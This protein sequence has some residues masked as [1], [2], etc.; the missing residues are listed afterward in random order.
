MGSRINFAWPYVT[1]LMLHYDFPIQ[2]EFAFEIGNM[3]IF[4][5]PLRAGEKIN[6]HL[7]N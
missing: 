5:Q 3:G 7:K 4:V 1:P 6:F 2:L